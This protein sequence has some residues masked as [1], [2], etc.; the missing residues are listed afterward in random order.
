MQPKAAPKTQDIPDTAP[1]TQD[2]QGSAPKTPDA[3]PHLPD[4]S[5]EFLL[6]LSLSLVTR[7]TID[8]ILANYQI[9]Y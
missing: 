2:T 9:Y 6:Y 7:V 3:G 8:F 5:E 1:K 4:I